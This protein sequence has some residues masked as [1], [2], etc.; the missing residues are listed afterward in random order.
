MDRW[1]INPRRKP[2]IIITLNEY[3]NEPSCHDSFFI[4][5]DK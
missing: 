1:V 4:P 5:K 2:T 3:I